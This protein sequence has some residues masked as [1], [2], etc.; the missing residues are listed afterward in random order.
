MKRR[1]LRLFLPYVL[2]F[3]LPIVL[4]FIVCQLQHGGIWPFG[5][6]SVLAN[7]AEGQYIP[8][9]TYLKNIIFGNDDFLYNFNNIIGGNALGFAGYYLLSPFNLL[10][11]LFDPSLFPFIFFVVTLLKI[12]CAGLTM[13]IFLKHHSNN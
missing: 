2:A 11:L 13:F 1:K 12:G 10:Y 4:F 3:L 6:M 7:D 5:K 8:F 9:F